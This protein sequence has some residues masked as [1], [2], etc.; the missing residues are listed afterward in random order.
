M[1][2]FGYIFYW[3]KRDIFRKSQEVSACTLDHRGIYGAIFRK[4]G[5]DL[6]PLPE[7][8]AA[9]PLMIKGAR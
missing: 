9:D 4:G 1:K 5:A 8:P 7:N 2:F 3:L 6:P